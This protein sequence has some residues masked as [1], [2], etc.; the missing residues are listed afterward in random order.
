ME[1]KIKIVKAGEISPYQGDQIYSVHGLSP[2]LSAQGADNNGGSVLIKGKIVVDLDMQPHRA[3][4]RKVYN[5]DGISPCLCAGMGEGGGV[6]PFVKG[7]KMNWQSTKDKKKDENENGIKIGDFRND[8]GLRIRKDG[9]CPTL[10]ASHTSEGGGKGDISMCPPL[11][12]GTITEATGN[13]AGSSTE[14]LS[15]VDKITK[16]IGEIRRLTPT[17]CE[18]LQGFPKNWTKYGEGE[19]DGKVKKENTLEIL[20]TLWEKVVAEKRERWGFTKFIALLKDEILRQDVHESQLLRQMEAQGVRSTRKLPCQAVGYCEEMFN[21]WEHEKC[22]NSSQGSKQIEQLIGE[23]TRSVSKL[24]YE[25]TQERGWVEHRVCQEP[26]KRQDGE[27][28]SI[29]FISDTQRYKTLGNAVTTNVI[30]ALIDKIYFGEEY[31]NE[32]Y[33]IK[34]EKPEIFW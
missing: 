10:A 26:E 3:S 12:M 20:Q 7:V 17:E 32:K 6:I 18:F 22:R 8:E 25:V 11:V 29:V 23:L 33:N 15:S 30:E 21:M 14:F 1:K 24:P 9:R 19:Y 28:F 5:K 13:R 16:T 2:T 34:I 27:V 31:F 4:G